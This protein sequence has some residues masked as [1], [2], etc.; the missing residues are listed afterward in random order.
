MVTHKTGEQMFQSVNAAFRHHFQIG[1]AKTQIKDGDGIAMGSFH[2][3]S[4]TYRWRCHA[5]VVYGKAIQQWHIV[6]S[7]KKKL[8][9]FTI[10]G[11]F[12][13]WRRSEFMKDAHL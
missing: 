5:G 11:N 1:S 6:T 2:G 12:L 7:S 13:P 9:F 3:F 4:N 10:S 8:I